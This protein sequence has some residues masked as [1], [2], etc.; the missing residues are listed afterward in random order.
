MHGRDGH[1]FVVV[2][3]LSLL[4]CDDVLVP[5]D[6]QLHVTSGWW[7]LV[8]DELLGPEGPYGRPVRADGSAENGAYRLPLDGVPRRW[9]VNTAS[10][11]PDVLAAAVRQ[12]G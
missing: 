12:D 8:P 2:G 3:D 11:D 10:A 9:L 7:G 5:T 1:A 4:A 6:A